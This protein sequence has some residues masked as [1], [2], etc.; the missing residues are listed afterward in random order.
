MRDNIQLALKKVVERREV[1]LI[2][3]LILLLIPITIR[4]PQFLSGENLSYILDDISILVIVSI[5]QFFV[6][7]SGG[8][9]LSVG[10][11]IAFSGMACGM[12]NQYYPEIPSILLLVF[13]IIIGFLL[14][15][16]NGVLVSYGKIP[17]IITTLGTMSIYRG[18]TFVLSGGTWVTSHEMSAGYIG[19]PRVK[20]LGISF[21][22]WIAILVIAICY[23][24]IRYTRTG[25]EI[26]SI[27]GNSVAAKFVG[28]KESR[29]RMATFLMSGVLCGLAG[30]L[31]TARYASAVNEMATGFEM[32]AVAACVLGGVN[33]AGGS[34]GIIGVVIGALFFG[35]VNNA[36][37]VVYISAFWQMF[38]QGL[39]VLFALA[40]NVLVDQR[41]EKVLLAQRRS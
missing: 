37:P 4:S 20:I 36:L 5:A 12:M 40:I 1:S 25:R 28:V 24:F 7:L 34:G 8:I 23:Y 21:L 11:I 14:G 19:L 18:F 41:K 17:A 2:V 29:V 10:S 39:V 32:Q 9:D 3:L 13:G 22:L 38:V 6:I 31:W 33:F 15:A 30:A 27:G 16:F 35:V 26:Y